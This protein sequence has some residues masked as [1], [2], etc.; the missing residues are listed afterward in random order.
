VSS[1]ASSYHAAREGEDAANDCADAVDPS[2]FLWNPR[3][4]PSRTENLRE[5]K[6]ERRRAQPYPRRSAKIR[7]ENLPSKKQMRPGPATQTA[8]VRGFLLAF[9]TAWRKP[10]VEAPLAKERPLQPDSA[11]ALSNDEC[12]ICQ[13]QLPFAISRSSILRSESRDHELQPLRLPVDHSRSEEQ[14]R[15]GGRNGQAPSSRRSAFPSVPQR[16]TL[17]NH[18]PPLA[19]PQSFGE[20]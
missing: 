7:G 20:L 14:D 4:N 17:A 2:S 10:L 19:R 18:R 9:V 16:F 3:Q 8:F 5:E 1:S 15:G 12:R 6:K 13:S 11:R